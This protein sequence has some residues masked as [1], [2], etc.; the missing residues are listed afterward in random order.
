VLVL[1]REGRATGA[2]LG[3]E[4]NLALE[5]KASNIHKGQKRKRQS[6]SRVRKEGVTLGTVV[7]GEGKSVGRGRGQGP[8]GREEGGEGGVEGGEG[9]G[10][11]EVGW[12]Q[13]DGEEERRKG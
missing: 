5:G 13:E 4:N 10:V 6:V 8:G 7:R 12:G 11:G 3:L 2:Q 1:R 9:G